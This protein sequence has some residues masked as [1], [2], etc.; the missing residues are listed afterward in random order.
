[1][2]AYDDGV[3]GNHTKRSVTLHPGESIANEGTVEVLFPVGIIV[4]LLALGTLAHVVG[5]ERDDDHGDDRP[6]RT[7]RGEI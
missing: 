7:L 2:R 5:A 4:I 6:R 1:M 3:V